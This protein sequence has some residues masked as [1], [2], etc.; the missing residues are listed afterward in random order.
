MQ[1]ERLGRPRLRLEP[2]LMQ[3]LNAVLLTYDF[4][5]VESHIS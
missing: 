4:R 1:G 3:V 2:A 5:L